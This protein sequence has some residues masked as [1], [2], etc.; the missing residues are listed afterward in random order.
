[1]SEI[2]G[3]PDGVQGDVTTNW[4][5]RNII[6]YYK[7][8]WAS[9]RRV[10]SVADHKQAISFKSRRYDRVWSAQLLRCSGALAA[11]VLCRPEA[12]AYPDASSERGHTRGDASAARF[13][14]NREENF[15]L[16]GVFGQRQNHP[17]RDARD[18]RRCGRAPDSGASVSPPPAAAR[19]SHGSRSRS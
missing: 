3:P 18:S 14:E 5:D 7:G 4:A 8:T 17:D 1:L 9:I 16:R 19:T 6:P 15:R 10:G 13:S 12:K 2:I 11:P